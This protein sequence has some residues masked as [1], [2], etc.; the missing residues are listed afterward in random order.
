MPSQTPTFSIE[1]LDTL[2]SLPE[3]QAFKQVSYDLLAIK[4]RQKL[5]E[6]GCAT[7]EDVRTLAE[8]VGEKGQV[9]GIDIDAHM[10][11]VAKQRTDNQTLPITLQQGDA[12]QLD[13]ADHSFH[14]CRAERL[15]HLLDNPLRALQ[16]MVRVVRPGGRV[17]VGEPD[18]ATLVLYPPGPSIDISVFEF[19]ASM[20]IGRQLPSLFNQVGLQVL[21]I[22]PVTCVITDFA[23]ANQVFHLKLQILSAVE[24]GKIPQ[25]D[26]LEWLINL[27]ESTQKRAFFSAMTGFIVCGEKPMG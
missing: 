11:E 1:Y 6:V 3:V 2:R 8:R 18:W 16:E 23:L 5:L 21:K 4:S 26:A 15:L 12:E 14:G 24:R 10:I 7:G 27:A 9:V 13:F 25:A 20:T 22:V 19:D 17:V